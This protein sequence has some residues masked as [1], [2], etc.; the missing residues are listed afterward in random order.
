MKGTPQG[1]WHYADAI[2]NSELPPPARLIAL[3]LCGVAK[4]ETGQVTRSITWLADST[5]L[6]RTTV[7]RHLKTLAAEG[8]MRR[9]PPPVWQAREEHAMTRYVLTVPAG[10]TVRRGPSHGPET[11]KAR[12]AAGH[13]TSSTTAPVAALRRDDAHPLPVNIGKP[14][15][16]ATPRPT[17]DGDC[18]NAHC[19]GDVPTAA[20]SR[21]GAT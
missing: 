5:G 13:S 2:R 18:A 1:G 9:F 21:S 14:C 19:G 7:K 17:R 12:A 16:C 10:F 11:S 20:V 3:S 15:T 6:G 8:W 4:S